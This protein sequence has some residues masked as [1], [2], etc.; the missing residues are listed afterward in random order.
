MARCSRLAV[1]TAAAGLLVAGRSHIGRL[2]RSVDQRA[3]IFAPRGAGLYNAVAPALL[4]PLYRRVAGDVAAVL[5]RTGAGAILEIGSGPGELAIEIARR[6]PD[7]EIIGVDLAEAMI[8]RASERAR[9]E[10]L[11]ERVRFRLADAAALPHA[12]ESF[13]AAVSTLSLHHWAHP[14]A[15]FRELGRVLR[16]GGVALIYDLRPF[17]Y[18]RHELD[19]FL[20]GSTFA[21]AGFEREL[22][23]LSPFPAF[24]VRVQLVRPGGP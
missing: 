13:D 7:A 19:A 2:L 15:V 1:A 23:R 6:R 12:D 22:V 5:P 24:F 4:G 14:A 17:T 21:V 10:G 18:A 8:E 16:P 9:A 3:Q 20:A 11:S